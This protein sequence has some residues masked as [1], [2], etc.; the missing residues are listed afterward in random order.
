MSDTLTQDMSEKMD[1][2][3]AQAE[4]GKRRILFTFYPTSFTEILYLLGM[5]R[6]KAVKLKPADTTTLYAVYE[7]RN[8]EF[9]RNR[10]VDIELTGA[11]NRKQFVDRMTRACES[12]VVV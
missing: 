1:E 10:M 4:K 11:F 7:S 9:D 5:N 12:I 2:V 3:L 6:G 8:W